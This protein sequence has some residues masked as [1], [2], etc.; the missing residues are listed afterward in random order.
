MKI[1]LIRKNYTPY[2]GAEKYLSRLIE[3]LCRR[4]HEVH[5]L[6]QRWKE[7]AHHGFQFYF[8]PIKTFSTLS[9]LEA[10]TFAKGTSHIVQKEKFDVIHSFERTLFQDVYRA[11]DGCHR[12]WLEQRKKIA[13]WYKKTSYFINPHHLVILYLERRLFNSPYLKFVI[14]NSQRGKKEILQHYGL[15]EEKIKVLYNGVD[16]EQFNPLRVQQERQM[17]REKW[18]IEKD[19]FVFLFVG[20]GFERKGLSFLLKA[21]SFLDK[22]NIKLLIVGKNGIQRYKKYAQKL[23]VAEKVLFAGPQKEIEYFYG[24]SDYFI[25]PSIYEPFSNACLE[26]LASGLPVI[27]SQINGAAELIK[28]G[29]NGLLINDPTNIWEISDKL[30]EAIQIWGEGGYREKIREI[31]P[32]TT[33]A[34]N[35]HDLL[36]I[37][38]EVIEAKKSID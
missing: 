30:Q 12:E 34:A 27:T 11:G 23:G 29:E 1:A 31:S 22:K 21:L 36:S 17:G 35:V 2:G 8:R 14:A 20:S 15:A 4:G 7:P 10:L 32:L 24:I 16:L 13:P 9:F 5:I 6:A 3:E 28:E 25:L 33:M 37:Y 26:A 18:K 38:N 19:D